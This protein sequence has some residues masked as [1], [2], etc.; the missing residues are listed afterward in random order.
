MIWTKSCP[1]CRG[2]LIFESDVHGRFVSCLQCGGILSN[3]EE[4]ALQGLPPQPIFELSAVNAGNRERA[5]KPDR[6]R[7]P[8]KV[9]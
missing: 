8:S 3:S 5:R 6:R 2:D 4:R 1:R 7:L 9:A